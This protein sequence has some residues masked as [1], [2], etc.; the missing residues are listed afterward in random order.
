ML[1]PAM[2]D[3]M[4]SLP[5]IISA[6]AV[7]TPVLLPPFLYW[8]PLADAITAGLTAFFVTTA[9]ACPALVEEL[10]KAGVLVAAAA[11]PAV[12]V[13]TNSRRDILSDVFWFTA[14][15]STAQVCGRAR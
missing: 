13:T 10:P 3:S 15:T 4:T 11:I 9:G 12:L 1:T 5:D 8:L 14:D 7:S 2:S 6:N